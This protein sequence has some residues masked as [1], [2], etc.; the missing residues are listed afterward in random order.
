[1]SSSTSQTSS[2]APAH[3]T[4]HKVEMKFN[5]AEREL[6]SLSAARSL[7]RRAYT[8]E[9][10]QAAER[11]A[12]F[13]KH[14]IAVGAADRVRQVGDHFDTTI[15]GQPVLVVRDD[16]GVRA[17]SNVCMH[18]GTLLCV[19][20]GNTQEF[21]CPNHGWRYSLDGS[22]I[23]SPWFDRVADFD[24]ADAGLR[25]L[26]AHV[27]SGIIFVNL[28]PD[29]APFEEILADEP[30]G[31]A[32]YGMDALRCVETRT[33]EFP[34]NWKLT[35]EN[36]CEA[37]HIPFVHGTLEGSLPLEDFV[38][39]VNE[40]MFS[41]WSYENRDGG[42]LEVL[43][44][45]GRRP[46]IGGLEG[47]E[48]TSMRYWRLFPNLQLLCSPDHVAILVVLPGDVGASTLSVSVLAVE[49]S[50][51]VEDVWEPLDKAMKEDARI[52]GRMQQG[53]AA[54][55]FDIGRLAVPFENNVFHF[56][57]LLTR[58]LAEDG[59]DLAR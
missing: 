52:V 41:T 19:G 57:Q 17:F 32:S 18:R 55:A 40:G 58:F 5:S 30:P 27:W 39:Q 23:E 33:Y 24:P 34:G 11:D 50:A 12:I 22:L 15:I 44:E 21:V 28:N 29:P 25:P 9:S 51:D 20:V 36:L 2:E 45:H 42:P 26:A 1:M 49:P 59:F 53:L 16:E 10:V 56:H 8:D 43:G 3:S 7:P 14:W 4:V 13:M 35:A 31:L 54:T 47:T 37:Y 6:Q 46:V 38:Y 48:L